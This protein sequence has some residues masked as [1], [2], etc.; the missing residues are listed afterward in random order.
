MHQ[1]D[2]ILLYAVPL[3]L[4]AVIIEAIVAGSDYRQQ[5]LSKDLWP[6]FCIGFG[7]LLISAASKGLIIGSF[8]LLNKISVFT[9]S[10]DKW[11][12]WV[13]CLLADDFTYYWFHRISH[14]VRFFWATHMVHHSSEIYSYSAALRQGWTG[15]ITGTF[16]FWAWMP[17]LGFNAYMVFTIKSISLIY[18]FWTHTALI[19]SIPAWM[20][21]IF[22]TPSHHRVHHGTNEEYIDKNYGGIFIIWDRL[23][24]TFIKETEQPVYGTVTKITARNPVKITLFEWNRLHKDLKH[25]DSGVTRLKYF[26]YPPGWQKKTINK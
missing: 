24:G 17:L 21:Y 25:S 3:F 8:I 22:N 16:L 19:K 23:Y 12:V 14:R 1:S 11:W 7:F 6:S 26:L 10:T 9:F 13:L 2:F 5:K 4:L 18:Q 20:E 15:N